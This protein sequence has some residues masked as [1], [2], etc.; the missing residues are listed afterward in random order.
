[1]PHLTNSSHGERNYSSTEVQIAN[2]YP[3]S[4]T[5]HDIF[6][7]NG[8][9]EVSCSYLRSIVSQKSGNGD[10]SDGE[11]HDCQE[12]HLALVDSLEKEFKEAECQSGLHLMEMFYGSELRKKCYMRFSVFFLCVF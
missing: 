5:L 12:F 2:A 7:S 6:S 4:D 1:M 9:I 8:D 11:Q 3:V 10:L